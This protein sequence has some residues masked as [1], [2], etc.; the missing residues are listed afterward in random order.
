MRTAL[1]LVLLSSVA[2]AQAPDAPLADPDA[3]GRVLVLEAGEI[4]PFRGV[5]LD[6]QEDV[7][8]ER[9]RVRAETGE[10]E[11]RTVAYASIGAGAAV[12]VALV[13]LTGLAAARKL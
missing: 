11:W 2:L 6:A 10:R 9:S 8:R 3:Q 1:A 13:L 7:H 5:L 4:A 12:T